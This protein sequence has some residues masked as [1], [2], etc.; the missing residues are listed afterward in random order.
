M[1]KVVAE[2]KELQ[3]P[4]K[5]KNNGYKKPKPFP[6]GEILA[7]LNKCKWILG[8]SVG[9]GGFGEVYSAQRESE[10]AAVPPYVIK[11]EPHQNGPLFV[12]MH[13]YLRVA[14]EE[15]ISEWLKKRKMSHLGVPRLHGQG[16]HEMG[17]E[18]YRF[19]VIDRFGRNLWSIFEENNRRFPTSTVFKI[20]LQI[21]DVLQYIHEKDYVHGDI[22]GTNLLLGLKKG[23]ENRVY[24]VDYGLAGKYSTKEFKPDK[25]RAHNGTIEY[26]SRDA[27]LGVQT[28][29][30]D[31]EVLGYNLL[32]WI[33]SRLPWEGDLQDPVKV[34][35]MKEDFMKNVPSSIKKLKSDVPVAIEQ[36]LNY[37][38][39]LAHDE[40]PDYNHCRKLFKDGMKGC[41]DA[42]GDKLLFKVGSDSLDAQVKSPPRKTSKKTPKRSTSPSEESEV[43]EEVDMP[44]AKLRRK[45]PKKK[46][47]NGTAGAP[48][49][50]DFPTIVAGR[51]AR[52]GQLRGNNA[53][54]SSD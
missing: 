15:F 41:R 4:V 43:D 18:K 1:P 50:R 24:L 10:K 28:R 47:A 19:L 2:K 20:A 30:G 13:F 31:L 32:H 27:H 40:E 17:G 48:S 23:T 5:K 45:T 25:K 21:I 53:D 14:K 44:Q 38:K 39:S 54:A 12:E 35:K 42:S 3:R 7:D 16:S 8:P 9:V 37:T 29:R 52:P 26:T 22:K 51:V 49:W 46:V 6:K 33:V 36:F 34:Q 11:I